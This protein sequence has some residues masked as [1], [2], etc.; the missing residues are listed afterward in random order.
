VATDA[1][2]AGVP[3]SDPVRHVYVHVPFCPTICPFCDFH[4]LERRAGLVEAYLDELARETEELAPLLAGSPPS[5]IY[6]GGG[7][8]S[9][10]REA[11]LARLLGIL[12]TTLGPAVDETTLEVHPSTA[13]PDRVAD[14]VGLGVD[15]LSVGLQS[16][17]DDVLRFL[18]RP[19][20]AAT[21]LRALELALGSGVRSVSV[22]LITAV[23]GQDARLDLERVAASGAHH[24]SA[25]TLTVEPGTPFH[26]A[27][28]E[29]DPDDEGEA[30]RLASEV[31][32]AAG[33]ERYEVSSHARPGHRSH[34]NRAYWRSDWWLGLGP[35]AAAHHPG[36]AEAEVARRRTNPPLDRWLTGERGEWTSVDP[37]DFVRT[38][39]LAGLRPVDGLDLAAVSS[40][41]GIDALRL[42]EPALSDLVE[43]GLLERHD[44][45]LRATESGRLILDQVTAQLL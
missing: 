6:L 32:G 26:R 38:A 45:R 44:G 34:H 16:T 42:L 5:T 11:E 8:P 30:L 13:S 41:A 29:V 22:D 2:P 25:Y 14:W 43:R 37:E 27:G 24:V 7:T 4:V 15:R 35:G 1:A 21:G 9:H 17:Q 28:V 33:L 23:P 31:L 40:R 20:D 3:P 19:H 39:V 18:G 36:T 10:L 12:H